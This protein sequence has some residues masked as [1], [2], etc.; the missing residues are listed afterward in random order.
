MIS[1][2]RYDEKSFVCEHSFLT[3]Q[4]VPF[5]HVSGEKSKN[6]YVMVGKN[7]EL[8]FFCE[9]KEGLE[10]CEILTKP[11]VAKSHNF[12][13]NVERHRVESKLL[14]KCMKPRDF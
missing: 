4:I 13:D 10:V 11:K 1:Y 8:F 5:E 12:D 9:S 2:W 3:P 14:Q 7:N 6:T